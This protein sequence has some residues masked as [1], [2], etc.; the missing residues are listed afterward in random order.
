[1]PIPS[2]ATSMSF[3]DT[4]RCVTA[5]RRL[6][7]DVLMR[8]PSSAAFRETAS[9]GTSRS[10]FT[11]FVSTADGSVVIHSVPPGSYRVHVWSETAE[12]AKPVDAQEILQ[13]AAAQ[14]N[15]GKIAM[16]STANPMEHHKN[17]FGEDYRPIHDAPY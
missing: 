13:V 17:K 12:S 5:R 1:M 6:A 14:V 11:R 4:S 3:R 9:A 2:A 7:P 8:S 15:L 16:Q 10:M